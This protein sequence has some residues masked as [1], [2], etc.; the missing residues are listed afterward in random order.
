MGRLPNTPRM[1]NMAK[2]HNLDVVSDV[3]SGMHDT[4]QL[5]IVFDFLRTHLNHAKKPYVIAGAR[6]AFQPR[7]KA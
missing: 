4:L 1:H 7:K 3:H 5:H 2:A 6:T